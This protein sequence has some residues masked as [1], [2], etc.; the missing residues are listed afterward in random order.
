M[1]IALLIVGIQ[2]H[3]RPWTRAMRKK[4]ERKRERERE[5]FVAQKKEQEL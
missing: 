5:R 4:R 1:K 3:T 2:S